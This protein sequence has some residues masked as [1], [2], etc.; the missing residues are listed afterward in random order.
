MRGGVSA[1][2]VV[3]TDAFDSLVLLF[4]IDNGFDSPTNDVDVGADKAAERAVEH[5]PW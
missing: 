3:D 5:Q 4:T 2:A 1:G